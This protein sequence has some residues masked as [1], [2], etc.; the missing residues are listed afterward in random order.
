MDDILGTKIDWLCIQIRNKHDLPVYTLPD[1]PW[2]YSVTVILHPF[3]DDSKIIL[4]QVL[5]HIYGLARHF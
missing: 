2:K 4:T 1:A 5:P 3:N